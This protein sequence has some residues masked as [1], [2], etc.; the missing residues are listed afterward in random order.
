MLQF[1]YR[2]V[3]PYHSILELGRIDTVMRLIETQFSL[4]VGDCWEHLCRQ[5][6]SGN[7]IDGI[8]YNMASRWW[9]KIF[10]ND[11]KE[12]TMIELDIVAES[13]DKK[14]ILIGECKWTN[15]ED[16][17]RLAHSFIRKSTK[18]PIRQKG[19]AGASR[20]FP[21]KDTRTSGSS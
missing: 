11:N 18:P 1:Y 21:E 5:Y 9:G 20:P 8:I 19:A 4:Y 13:F 17:Q 14:H 3:A 7:E 6:V 2:F 10:P 15:G 12:G 16:A